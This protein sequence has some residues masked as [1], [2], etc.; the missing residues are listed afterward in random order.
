MKK[1]V[2]ILLSL[3]ILCGCSDPSQKD[4]NND[5]SKTELQS[6]ESSKKEI[7]FDDDSGVL[8]AD[9]SGNYY[10]DGEPISSEEYDKIM[11]GIIDAP[12]SEKTQ[13]VTDVSIVVPDEP[14]D[15]TDALKNDPSLGI[16]VDTGDTELNI[17]KHDIYNNSKPGEQGVKV[18]S[19]GDTMLI[20]LWCSDTAYFDSVVY[21]VSKDTPH[22]DNYEKDEYILKQEIFM[23]SP[24]DVG[25]VFGD[26]TVPSEV[27]P[28]IYELRFVCGT[29]EGY[30]PYYI[31]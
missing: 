8:M 23:F 7:S 13:V 17:T 18:F 14:S 3:L 29:E 16:Y 30:I 4:K 20:N 27:T 24:V 2:Y 1:I 21:I 31:G 15:T 11:Q 22:K 9:G 5:T 26:I 12:V 25:Q 28:G 6:S 10:Y 19:P